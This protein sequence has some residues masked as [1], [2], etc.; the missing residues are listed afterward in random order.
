MN[1]F[2]KGGTVQLDIAGIIMRSM[3][4]HRSAKSLMHCH[5]FLCKCN[6][7]TYL[8]Y[9]KNCGSIVISLMLVKS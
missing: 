3:Q 4:I 6:L 2:L 7:L 5:I 1:F 8:T 9:K